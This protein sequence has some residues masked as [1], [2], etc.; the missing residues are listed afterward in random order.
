MANILTGNIDRMTFW[1]STGELERLE[2]SNTY[3]PHSSGTSEILAIPVGRLVLRALRGGRKK[4][5]KNNVNSPF[6]ATL[7]FKFTKQRY[8]FPIE[9][10]NNTTLERHT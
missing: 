10:T 3:P 1:T 2:T 5:K 4:H 8:D 7:N 9:R 6:N